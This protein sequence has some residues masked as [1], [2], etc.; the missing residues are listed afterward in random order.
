MNGCKENVLDGWSPYVASDDQ[1]I[2]VQR[3]LSG[4][5]SVQRAGI[6]IRIDRE[7]LETLRHR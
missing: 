3:D 4:K 2:L 1:E 5:R 7:L 6:D